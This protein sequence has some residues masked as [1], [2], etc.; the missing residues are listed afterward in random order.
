MG[1]VQIREAERLSKWHEERLESFWNSE[2]FKNGGSQAEAMERLFFS[3]FE[4]AEK[5][6][7]ILK[8]KAQK[9]AE[10]AER[11]ARR[12]EAEESL[13]AYLKRKKLPP[14]SAS[15]MKIS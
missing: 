15:S 10:E 4:K 3:E 12:K 9:E 11:E 13:Q 14:F 7:R 5:A 8:A 2:A 6:L 1:I